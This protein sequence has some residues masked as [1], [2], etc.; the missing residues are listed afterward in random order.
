MRGGDA[1]PD[2]DR[3]HASFPL[4]YGLRSGS[5]KDLSCERSQD[6]PSLGRNESAE[7]QGLDSPC[8]P[9]TNP[10]KLGNHRWTEVILA[11]AGDRNVLQ[12]RGAAA[13]EKRL[14]GLGGSAPPFSASR[15]RHT[16]ATQFV[17]FFCY[18]VSLWTREYGKGLYRILLWSRAGTWKP[19]RI[20]IIETW[21]IRL[22]RFR[23]PPS[24]G[25]NRGSNPLCATSG[26]FKPFSAKRPVIT[27]PKSLQDGGVP[28]RSS[29]TV[30]VNCSRK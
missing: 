6:D 15:A 26:G 8:V 10:K 21:R 3:E 20:S 5:M 9:L 30:R 12:D 24:Q 16:Q 19:F 29:C 14:S 23:T 1:C 25:G 27:L 4:P 13:L 7:L 22:A 11:Q 18:H 28:V 2:N 17:R